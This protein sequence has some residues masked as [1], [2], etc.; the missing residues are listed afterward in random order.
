MD[1]LL[2]FLELDPRLFRL[3]GPCACAKL[4]LASAA[5]QQAAPLLRRLELLGEGHLER[6]QGP[7]QVEAGCDEQT[8]TTDH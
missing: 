1:C 2:G 7:L 4:S 8:V 5:L 6:R 3:L